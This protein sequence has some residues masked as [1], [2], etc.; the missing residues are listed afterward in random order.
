MF[1]KAF[2]LLIIVFLFSLFVNTCPATGK[3]T[4]WHETFDRAFTIT[5]HFSDGKIYFAISDRYYVLDCVTGKIMG[6]KFLD[7][8]P[9]K[10]IIT[11]SAIYLTDYCNVTAI[12]MKDGNLLWK[13]V[14]EEL[15]NLGYWSFDDL[16]V[17]GNRLFILSR[18][19]GIF[20]FDASSGKKLW[21]YEADRDIDDFE[22]VNEK[23]YIISRDYY[24][25]DSL[26]EINL[27]DG[28][29]KREYNFD[30]D[31]L[32]SSSSVIFFKDSLLIIKNNSI[33]FFSLSQFDIASSY[34]MYSTGGNFK[35]ID[36]ILFYVSPDHTLSYLN[37]KDGK[38]GN[39]GEE[40]PKIFGTLQ[41]NVFKIKD[42]IYYQYG[43][44]NQGVCAVNYSTGEL[45]WKKEFDG[46]NFLYGICVN[47]STDMISIL[48]NTGDLHILDGSTGEEI[49]QPVNTGY[50]GYI[51]SLI[52][53]SFGDD[54]II[55]TGDS[56]LST[57][58]TKLSSH[59]FYGTSDFYLTTENYYARGAK[60]YFSGVN[61]DYVDWKA[62]R[63][64]DFKIEDGTYKYD[65]EEVMKSAP[66]Q[67]GTIYFP[68]SSEWRYKTVT[69]PIEEGGIYL[70]KA[71]ARGAK[72][73]EDSQ[74]SQSIVS[75]MGTVVKYTAKEV[76]V[77][78]NNIEK[79][80][81]QAGASVRVYLNN[82]LLCEG[83]ADEKG[84]FLKE[85]EN[86]LNGTMTVFTEYEGNYA[87]YSSAN[88]EAERR[89][90]A[91]VYT[92]RPVYRPGHTVYFKGIVRKDEGETYENL[93]H[94]QAQIQIY[95]PLGNLLYHRK[96]TT[97][98]YGTFNGEIS[99]AG[100]CPLGTYNIVTTVNSMS[101]YATFSVEEYRKPEYKVTLTPEK[102]FYIQGRGDGKVVLQADY[103]FGAPVV[104]AEVYY[105]VRS[106]S[107]YFS[108]ST[109]DPQENWYDDT[110]GTY[111]YSYPDEVVID[112]QGV[113]DENGRLVIE[114]PI[115]K[116][117]DNRLYTVEAVMVD[118]SRREV[119]A[120]TSFI[121]AKGEFFLGAWLE[122]YVYAPG[123]EVLVTVMA[124][125]IEGRPVDTEAK[126]YFQWRKW[127]GEQKK[128]V[129]H[130]FHSDTVKLGDK[131][132]YEYRYTLPEDIP[133]DQIFAIAEATDSFNNCISVYDTSWVY[134]SV[135]GE[136]YPALEIITDKFLY[137]YGDNAKILINTSSLSEPRWALV[138]LERNKIESY[139]VIELKEGSTLF[140]IPIKESY[141]PNVYMTVCFMSHGDL[142]RGTKLIAVPAKDKFLDIDIT[143]DKEEY[144]P[145][146]EAT[147]T[148]KTTDT[149]GNPVSAEVS[150]GFV[151]EAIYAIK[152]ETTMDICRFFYGKKE[153]Y[154][155]TGYSI[156]EELSAGGVQK[157]PADIKVRK[158]FKD[159]AYWNPTVV[160]DENGE[161]K[162]VFKLPD[163]LTTWRATARGVTEDTLVGSTIS[164]SIV[165]KKLL[166]RLE[167]PRF[168]TQKDDLVVSTIIHNYT[169]EEQKV[170]AVMDAKGVTLTGESEKIVTIK[171]K[172]ACLLDWPVKVEDLPE[173]NTALFTAYAFS[174]D[175]SQEFSDAMEL[176]VPI[177]PHGQEFIETDSG[178]IKGRLVKIIELP[179]EAIDESKLVEI[180]FAPSLM[181]NL[182]TSLEYLTSYPY[183]CTEQTM[184]SFLP[185]IFVYKAM[186]EAGVENKEL[187]KEI[188]LMVKTGLD[189]LY[190]YQHYDGG[191]GWWQ[192]DP[193]NPYL[194]AL[195]VYGLSEA[196]DAGFSIDTYV[197]NQG[198]SALEDFDYEAESN[199]SELRS[200]LEKTEAK[201]KEDEFNPHLK[202]DR[203]YLL[204]AINEYYRLRAYILHSLVI[205]E[206]ISE[207]A[208]KRLDEIFENRTSLNDYTG[209]LLS[210]SYLEAGDKDK[211]GRILSEII[212]H[213]RVLKDTCHW[214][215]DVYNYGWFDNDV[216]TTSY[217]LQA[218]LSLDPKNEKIPLT[219]NW[220][221]ENREG[222]TYWTSTKD[223]AAAVY[224]LANYVKGTREMTPNYEV[225]LYL[226]NEK[227]GQFKITP[228]ELGKNSGYKI[229]KK[230]MEELKDRLDISRLEKLE[231]KIF[232]KE[233]MTQRLSELNFSQEE[234][235]VILKH[236]G[237]NPFTL[238]ITPDKFVKDGKNKVEIIREG[239]GE[240]YYTY[241]QSY[242]A[243]ADDLVP[244][245]SGFTVK[246]EYFVDMPSTR[247]S[248]DPVEILYPLKWDIVSGDKFKVKITIEGKPEYQYIMV[249]D[250]LPAGCEIDTEAD[251]SY[252]NTAYYARRENRDNRVV[253][254]LNDLYY[255]DGKA[256][257]VY[258]LR[259]ETPGI[260]HA[261]PAEVEM[262]YNPHIKGSSSERVLIILDKEK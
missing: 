237:G 87:L 9:Q 12:S 35:I 44:D 93:S 180:T 197:L 206:G 54:F 141:S 250:Y 256:E 153:N 124:K 126:L 198:I 190:S 86:P 146:D 194:T 255:T 39:N 204:Y 209:A 47:P 61:L 212:P 167:T 15:K 125:D 119:E 83:T 69:L 29:L 217:V 41:N 183:G 106:S 127:D 100:D 55:A 145:G 226:N 72:E 239:N 139:E 116:S 223:T 189:T 84:I 27:S 50:T 166:L 60:A 66:V 65:R 164:K 22:I 207:K 175:K 6:E 248:F 177:L 192:D 187:E 7:F 205:A 128:Y 121:S 20:C 75:Q 168:L 195:V 99:L 171:P 57:G 245:D 33:E 48:E 234:I 105:R 130:T 155:I 176:S 2:F 222:G 19:K 53:S 160:T 98:D 132:K 200:E 103:Y 261:L 131:G 85:F 251:D 13:F 173:N 94:K 43:S 117:D 148:I 154:V 242:Y 138:C 76:L 18:Y 5:P 196:R 137:S 52:S 115:K 188:P 16:K 210:L 91:Y 238:K 140:E 49:E 80:T 236:S 149:S 10:H 225:K 58:N 109:P 102:S 186:K 30:S 147:F 218:M 219:V 70:I 241:Y 114:V 8:A 224:A 71:K 152:P 221:I 68:C 162:V 233:N 90:Q 185:D 95:D 143:A 159:T 21:Y 179:S 78:A 25:G 191:W 243:Y 182:F 26:L 144:L 203:E 181:G 246:K 129:Y 213:G 199:I 229:T 156:P 110:S 73:E 40:A 123:D 262:M 142:V 201:I 88:K 37:L 157:V 178:K 111:Y 97:N 31:Y 259:G 211:A 36:D 67:E 104:G 4:R 92:E 163:N 64:K 32:P 165:T 235:E 228:E 193:S 23:C 227:E 158:D 3:V 45:I 89:Y 28:K 107:Y 230:V 81:P 172:E 214:E 240:L 244:Q 169:A 42:K 113:T 24:K 14:F 56:L 120:Y 170:K 74:V 79:N 34:S 258:T 253:F 133:S 208:V 215:P 17:S 118:E 135:A 82:Q 161:A 216:E 46:R 252:W 231:D 220:L 202:E 122:N 96:P 184:H 151:D 260:F 108:F 38:K 249:E 62:Y 112:S 247:E 51:T 1:K 257:I 11:D 134:G 232:C 63:V 174:V 77:F 59:N 101:S 136:D 254:F 150:V